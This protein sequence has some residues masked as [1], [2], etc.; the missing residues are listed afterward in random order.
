MVTLWYR[1]IN[2]KWQLSIAN[3]NHQ[4]VFLWGYHSITGVISLTYPWYNSGHSSVPNKEWMAAC[5]SK[6]TDNHW[7]SM[8]V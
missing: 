3:L 4:R 1:D 7:E 6:L 8:D 2:Y 5:R